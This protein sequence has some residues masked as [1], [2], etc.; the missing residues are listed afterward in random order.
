MFL[1]DVGSSGA[2]LTCSSGY[3][4]TGW[5]HPAPGPRSL[6]LDRPQA[7]VGEGT[8]DVGENSD[9]ALVEVLE[10]PS[11]ASADDDVW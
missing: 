10:L 2:P 11:F 1:R 4:R 8:P 5:R 9:D 7:D 3:A 6:L